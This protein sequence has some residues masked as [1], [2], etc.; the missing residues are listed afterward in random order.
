M[1]TTLEKRDHTFPDNIEASINN[2]RKKAIPSIKDRLI[3]IFSKNIIIYNN[4]N[5]ILYKIHQDIEKQIKDDLGLWQEEF[6]WIKFN[7]KLNDYNNHYIINTFKEKLKALPLVDGK[8]NEYISMQMFMLI[9]NLA[10][11]L[12]GSW[13]Y[14]TSQDYEEMDDIMATK[15]TTFTMGVLRPELESNID[16]NTH[17]TKHRWNKV[18]IRIITPKL[19]SKKSYNNEDIPTLTKLSESLIQDKKTHL[20]PWIH[21]ISDNGKKMISTE[22]LREKIIKNESKKFQWHYSIGG[23]IHFREGIPQEKIDEFQKKFWFWSTWFQLL[24]ANKSLNLPPSCSPNIL[25]FYILA[26]EKFGLIEWDPELQLGIP[27]RLPNRAAGILWSITLLSWDTHTEYSPEAFSTNQN[28][29]TW[30]RIMAY[31]AW[32]LNNNFKYNSPHVTWRTDM[33]GITDIKNIY[34]YHI[35]WSILSQTF[36]WGKHAKIGKLFIKEYVE[37]LKKYNLQWILEQE[38]IYD[39]KN[40]NNISAQQHYELIKTI[41]DRQKQDRESFLATKSEDWLIVF[42]I[43]NLLNKYKKNIRIYSQPLWKMWIIK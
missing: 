38:R 41:T 18:W 29:L 36:Y 8:N 20:L 17:S 40:D 15:W 39:Q 19:S 23:K 5:N 12:S 9:N 32:I 26:L 3:T 13:T 16:K 10:M 30:A 34:T 21:E 14:M 11:Y 35:V 22:T 24:H 27:W 31:D 43:K 25:A 6:L 42:E 28:D 1:T 7:R 37:I 4:S 33:L 2:F